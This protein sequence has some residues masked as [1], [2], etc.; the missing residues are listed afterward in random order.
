M[1]LREL[2]NLSNFPSFP[3][4]WAVVKIKKKKSETTTNLCERMW[5]I[6]GF[7]INTC[8]FSCQMVRASTLGQ[9]FAVLD[10]RFSGSSDEVWAES[11]V[12]NEDFEP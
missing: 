7:S 12:T 10:H 11:L 6:V 9:A 2:F 1:L 4:K 8:F 5:H 3:A